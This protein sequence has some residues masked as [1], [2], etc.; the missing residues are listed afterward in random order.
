VNNVCSEYI[1]KLYDIAFSGQYSEYRLKILDELEKKGKKIFKCND[2][3]EGRDIGIGKSKLLIN[4][5]YNETYKVLEGDSLTTTGT[6][7]LKYSANIG[8]VVTTFDTFNQFQI[9]V[10]FYSSD[11][12]VVP[13]IKNIIATAVV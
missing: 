4:I 9:K 12:T 7:N 2:Y 11:T 1:N 13:K 6:A 3:S 10:V 8:G 5:H